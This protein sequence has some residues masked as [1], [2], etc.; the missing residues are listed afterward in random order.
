MSG[1]G[2][3]RCCCCSH[4]CSL[5]CL[6]QRRRLWVIPE[7]CYWFQ[8]LTHVLFLHVFLGEGGMGRCL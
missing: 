8:W 6:F 5:G 1:G 2:W 7:A 4:I 3:E